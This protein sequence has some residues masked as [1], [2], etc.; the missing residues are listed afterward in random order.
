MCKVYEQVLDNEES[1]LQLVPVGKPMS[2][3]SAFLG[4][5]PTST[6]LWNI[7]P[8]DGDYFPGQPLDGPEPL[9]K[10]L[11]PC[12]EDGDLKQRLDK[13]SYHGIKRMTVGR[14]AEAL[15]CLFKAMFRKKKVEKEQEKDPDKSQ[16]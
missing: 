8:D 9:F 7:F 2:A 1:I 15:Q 13:V 5:K 11:V 14:A 6:H 10:M 4:Y 3:F 16:A 12:N